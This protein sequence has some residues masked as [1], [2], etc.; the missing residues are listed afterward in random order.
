MIASDI[1]RFAIVMTLCAASAGYAQADA[2]SCGRGRDPH[3]CRKAATADP[4]NAPLLA[5][6]SQA[7]AVANQPEPAL[8]AIEGALGAGAANPDY[9]RARAILATWAGVYDRARDSYRQL[10]TAAS[11]SSSTCAELRARERLG[12]RHRQRRQR[13]SELPDRAARRR[14]RVAGARAHRIVARQL[15]GRTRRL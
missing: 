8:A 12:R 5:R 14:R 9:L 6:L 10:A 4:A 7:Y 2:G 3:A 13:V 1:L 15:R 11:R